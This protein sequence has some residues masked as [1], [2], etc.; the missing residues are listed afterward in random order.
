[1]PAISRRIKTAKLTAKAKKEEEVKRSAII[2][3]TGITLETCYC[4]KCCL[5]KPPSD[6]FTAVDS[7]LDSSGKFSICKTCCNEIYD[8]M[9]AMERSLSKALLKTCRI[10]NVRYDEKAV[11]ATEER[12]RAMVDTGKNISYNVFGIYKTKLGSVNSKNVA[13]RAIIEDYTFIE[14]GNEI[15]EG[16]TEEDTP[17]AVDLQQ[18]WGNNYNYDDYVFLEKELAEWKK[19]HKS[20]TKAEEFLLTEICH[21][22]LEIRKARE[23]GKSTAGLVK[24]LQDLMKTA[25]VDP[26]KT[27]MIGSGK[28]MDTFSSFIKTIEENEPIDTFKDDAIFKDF[29]NILWY[30]KKFVTRP[31]SN[32]FGLSRI[33]N[34]EDDSF[35]EEIEENENEFISKLIDDSVDIN[36]KESSLE[37]E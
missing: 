25:N 27:A 7:Y 32:F 1:M 16:I 14:P 2:T 5:Q 31:I 33:F 11:T 6:F 29:D 18:F 10:L 26:A 24:E 12:L 34:L 15:V 20:D 3:N 13:D 22:S 21:K 23:I 35:Q 17:D 4:R 36:N 8:K 19:T 28:A 9:Y 30:F 37:E